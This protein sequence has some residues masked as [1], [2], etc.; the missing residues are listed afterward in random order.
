MM[1]R[2]T[3]PGGHVGTGHTPT[4]STGLNPGS[5]IPAAAQPQP[6]PQPQ[7]EPS[8][9][10]VGL[11]WG[12]GWGAAAGAA[13]AVAVALGFG[14]VAATDGALGEAVG[15]MVL[16]G[17]VGGMVGAVIGAA[18]GGISGLLLGA[19]RAERFAPVVAAVAAGA[20]Y[21]WIPFVDITETPIQETLL[22]LLG[23]PVFAAI[24]Y[25]AG[26]GFARSMGSGET[27][28]P[29]FAAPAP[30]PTA[31]AERPPWSWNG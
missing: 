19:F 7:P 29:G 8:R 9:V 21:G 18:I 16:V 30:A 15:L 31:G 23:V 6:Q 25:W 26:R 10:G 5:G 28:T 13:S 20:T 4:G 11:G 22:L 3:G 24:G 17:A 1:T 14:V 27:G 2:S 12:I